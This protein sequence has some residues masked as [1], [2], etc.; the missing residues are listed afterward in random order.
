MKRI[1]IVA[2][3]LMLG[4]VGIA[5]AQDKANWTILHYTAVDNNLEGAAF[6]DYYEMQSVGSGEGVNIVTEL[7]R[8]EGF[9]TRFGDW[10]DTRRFYIEKV[11]PQPELDIAGK[12]DALVAYFVNAGYGDTDS[13][14]AQ[15]TA[16]DDATIKNIYENNNVGVNFDQTAVQDLGEVDMGDPQSLSDFIVWGAQNYPADHYMIVIGSHGGG[17]RGIGPD[18][19]GGTDSMLELPE[20]DKALGDAQTTLGIDKFDIVGFDACLMAVTDVAVTLES[21]ANYVL[22]SQEVIPSNGWEYFNSIT[23]MQQNPDWDA[24]Q[25]GQSF[26]DNYMAYYAGQ[27]QRTKVDLGLV[28]TAG[29]PNLLTAL[30]DFAKVVK[31]NTVDLLS[32]LGTARNNS[33]AFGTSLGDRAN[34]YSYV[35]LKDFMTWFSLQTTISEDAYNASQAVIAAYD[36]AVVYSQA[37]SKLPRANGLGIYLP[38]TQDYYDAYGTDYPADAPASFA[39]W[40]DYL[41]QFYTTIKTELDGSALQLDIKNVF[42]VGGE[43]SSTVDNPVV[44]F[45][46]AGKGVIDLA[47]TITYVE[48]DGT[49]TI[50]DSSP[51]SYTSTLPTGETLI[52]YPN[53]LTPSTFTWGVEFPYISDGTNKVLSL[54]QSS[55]GSGSEGIVQGTYVN[56]EGSQPAY[57]IFDTQT[58]TYSG[59]LAIADNSPYQVSP[60]P[61]DQ[62][63]VD[64][65]S[66][67]P[68][69]E[70]SVKPLTDTPLTYG[71][72]PF[73]FNYS[74]AISGDYEVG[75]SMSDL[76]SNRIYKKVAITVNNDSV[77]GTLRGYTDTNEGVY[78]QYPFAWGDSYQLTNDDGSMTNALSD[79][80]GTE[81]IYV[82]TFA[83][84]NVQ[85]ALGTAL[86]KIDGDKG[87]VQ[88]TTLSGLPA[89]SVTYSFT[90]DDGTMTY[91]TLYSVLNEASGSAVVFNV[92][93]ATEDTQ[94]AIAGI[95]DQS[96]KLFA[97]PA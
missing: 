8:A 74:P 23:S 19:G 94:A 43:T 87:D 69:G 92:Q 96:V 7:D 1:M 60:L 65:I 44:S 88:E 72:T 76:A 50:V 28:D 24:M 55:S 33:Q 53:E 25:V 91:G 27:G 35:D 47:Y 29:L 84:T 20:I 38:P 61:G 80:A 45:D 75:L 86:D 14:T 10:T 32:A 52:E 22:F 89:S 15:V 51:I 39:F 34:T 26:I 81:S 18:T 73:T 13:I 3:V 42:T 11:P 37:D 62:F 17:W 4:A 59:T 70:V 54:L 82:D 36:G 71:V 49:R 56:K 16:L 6:N 93:T 57:L 95:V 85:T 2:A 58:N 5:H 9:E 77:D 31:A 64:L 90:G 63:I 41:N 48:A 83:D 12:R 67:T 68:E 46:A 40:Q 30:D 21:H 66:I 78:F 97:P 79:D